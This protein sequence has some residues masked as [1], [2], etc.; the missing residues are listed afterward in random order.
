LGADLA[1][2]IDAHERAGLATLDLAKRDRRAIA[3]VSQR[4]RTPSSG[5]GRDR[6]QRAADARQ[7]T[8]LSGQAARY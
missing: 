8:V 3:D 5:R 2:M 1:N 4:P 6:T 7:Q